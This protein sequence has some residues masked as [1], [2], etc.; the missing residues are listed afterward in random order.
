MTDLILASKSASRQAILRGAGIP[1]IAQPS[2]VDEGAIKSRER[3][4]GQSPGE[5]A[6]ILAEA[7]AL[8]LSVPEQKIVIGC[9]Q[10]LEFEGHLYDKPVDMPE[11]KARLLRMAGHTHY[12]RSGLVVAQGGS[13][14]WRHRDV[15]R[16]TMRPVTEAGVEAYLDCVGPRILNT[17]G[18]YELEAEGVRLFDSVEGDYFTILG[19]SLF[20][21]MAFLREREILPW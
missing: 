11:A 3:A 7:K 5:I 20:P 16:L 19:L 4:S 14:I 13:I 21:L 1:F 18:G 15:A 17:V 12:L 9:D 8:A 10:V 2:D 6:L